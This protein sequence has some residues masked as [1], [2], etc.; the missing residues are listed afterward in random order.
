MGDSYGRFVD[1][2]S[3]QGDRYFQA[4]EYVIFSNDFTSVIADFVLGKYFLNKSIQY[5]IQFLNI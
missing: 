1:N 3:F 4:G 5:Y 2:A